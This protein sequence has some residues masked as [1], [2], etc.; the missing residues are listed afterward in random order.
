MTDER[1]YRAFQRA[2]RQRQRDRQRE[3]LLNWLAL[4]LGLTAFYLLMTGGEW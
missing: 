3:K 2:A 1:L 4:V